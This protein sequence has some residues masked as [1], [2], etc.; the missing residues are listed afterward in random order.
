MAQRHKSAAS[1]AATVLSL[2]VLLFFT[3]HVDGACQSCLYAPLHRIGHKPHSFA[4]P[5]HA[6]HQ[7]G[8]SFPMAAVA[9]ARRSPPALSN[10]GIIILRNLQEHCTW[11]MKPL[12]IA[13]AVVATRKFVST[14]IVPYATTAIL[15]AS[16]DASNKDE[17]GGETDESDVAEGE[18]EGIE[19]VSAAMVG[20]IGFYKNFIS[21]L[22]PPACRFYPTC[23]QYGVQAIEKFGPA[24]GC[25]LIAWRLLRCSPVGGKGYDPPKWPPVAFNYVG[26]F[27]L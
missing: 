22:L 2:F 3:N 20:T 6:I 7:H 19:P 25:L 15:M 11:I 9:V 13:V 4:L 8:G 23:S 14:K 5:P 27:D 10:F 24:K 18:K 16:E 17:E 1:M 12:A 26:S 21:P